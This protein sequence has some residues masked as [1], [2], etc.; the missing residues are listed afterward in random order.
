MKAESGQIP[1]KLAGRLKFAYCLKI[2][3]SHF[4]RWTA[5]FRDAPDP[6]FQNEGISSKM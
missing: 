5:M 4:S 2:Y 6:N 1:Q 3:L